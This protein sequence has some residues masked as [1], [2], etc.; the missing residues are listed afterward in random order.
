MMRTRPLFTTLI[1]LTFGCGILDAMEENERMRKKMA[2][3]MAAKRST[4]KAEACTLSAQVDAL[5]VITGVEAGANPRV[6]VNVAKWA[7]LDLQSM[8]RMVEYGAI[9]KLDHADAFKDVEIL[10]ASDGQRLA[11]W[12]FAAGLASDLRDA[13]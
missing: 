5:G 6:L 1:G 2:A 4:V 3:D 9:C 7:A 8:T 11:A 13:P 12:S 10:R